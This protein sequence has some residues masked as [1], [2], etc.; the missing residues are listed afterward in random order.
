MRQT[1]LAQRDVRENILAF[2][3]RSFGTAQGARQ[4]GQKEMNS[5]N[6]PETN[7]QIT[8]RLLREIVETTRRLEEQGVQKTMSF[9]CAKV[10]DMIECSVPPNPA[11]G[12]W[13]EHVTA[14]AKIL[15]QKDADGKILSMKFFV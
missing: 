5:A 13:E 12:V 6:T 15:L 1:A 10:G 7:K 4:K 9:D 2:T 11:V 8:A 3:L 14:S